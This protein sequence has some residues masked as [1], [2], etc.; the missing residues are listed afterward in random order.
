MDYKDFIKPGER[1]VYIPDYKA[2]GFWTEYE[3]CIVKIGEY[4]PYY[5]DGSADPKPEEYNE[6]CYVEAYPESDKVS[7]MQ[8]RLNDLH[9]IKKSGEE[10]NMVYDCNRYKLVGKVLSIEYKLEDC[11]LVQSWEPNGYVVLEKDG[12]WIVV[13]E[14]DCDEERDIYSLDFDELVELR[15]QICI[16][17]IYIHHYTN[18]FGV[19]PNELC[20]LGDEYWSYLCDEYG[21]ENAEEN[22]TPEHFAEYFN[23]VLTV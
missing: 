3:E 12:K 15:K 2:L 7:E 19:N 18:S 6:Y 20:E 14:D 4:A 11:G 17:S 21:E 5:T 22:D 9:P 8:F 16:G 23:C 13:D 10:K 1:C